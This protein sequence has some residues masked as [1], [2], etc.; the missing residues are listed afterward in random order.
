V[1]RFKELV[2]DGKVDVNATIP[3][4]DTIYLEWGEDMSPLYLLCRLFK[5]H[6]NVFEL[7]QLLVLKG[8]DVNA[9]VAIMPCDRDSTPLHALPENDELSGQLMFDLVQLLLQNGANVNIKNGGGESPIFRFCMNYTNDNLVDILQ[10]LIDK[11]ADVNILDS[12]RSR[13]L[14]AVCIHYKNDNLFDVIRLLI[15]NGADYE[16]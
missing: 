5:A 7:V 16:Q 13:P 8:A 9:K 4:D 14:H 11:G 6:D 10:L 15:D 12:C 3:V 2:N 1:T